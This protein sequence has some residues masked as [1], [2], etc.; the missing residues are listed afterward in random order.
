MIVEVNNIRL[1]DDHEGFSNFREQIE[2]AKVGFLMLLSNLFPDAHFVFYNVFGDLATSDYVRDTLNGIFKSFEIQVPKGEPS[3][4][5][6]PVNN[7]PVV[8][9]DGQPRIVEE[10]ETVGLVRTDAPTLYRC[11]YKRCFILVEAPISDRSQGSSFESG[12]LHA[13]FV[14]LTPRNALEHVAIKSLTRDEEKYV[15]LKI[16]R[17]EDVCF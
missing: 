4:N 7:V 10:A 5:S 11:P 1:M 6:S 12:G 14:D 15:V 17:G 9:V 3:F 13:L 8:L 16:L 2:R